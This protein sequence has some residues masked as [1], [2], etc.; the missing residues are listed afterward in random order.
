[1]CNAVAEQYPGY[2]SEEILSH[3]QY[4]WNIVRG[5]NDEILSQIILVGIQS[6]EM[7]TYMNAYIAKLLLR[8]TPLHYL[9]SHGTYHDSCNSFAHRRIR[10]IVFGI[11]CILVILNTITY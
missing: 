10:G 1:M 8:V 6:V 9:L 5:V 2:T 7:L 4:F 11:T 3:K